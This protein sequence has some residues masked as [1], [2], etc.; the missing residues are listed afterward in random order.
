MIFT[1]QEIC[2]RLHCSKPKAVTLLGK[3]EEQHLIQRTR[4]EKD[5]PYHIVVKA[6]QH[7][8][9]KLDLPSSKNM[10]W[11]SKEILPEQVK[12]FDLN[13]TDNN[14]TDKN[15]TEKI[16]LLEGEIKK[17]I[18]YD[19]LLSA[20]PKDKVDSVVEVMVQTLASSA[21]TISLGGIPVA[22][23]IV[24]EKLRSVTGCKVDYLFD[25]LESYQEP[26]LSYRAFY[27]AR[28]CDPAGVVE[29]YYERR[30]RLDSQSIDYVNFQGEDDA[31]A[32]YSAALLQAFL[33]DAPAWDG[34]S[35]EPYEAAACPN[36]FM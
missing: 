22:A 12:K 9:T 35:Q 17:N 25:N 18:E 24:K 14:K 2:Q 10:T 4:P 27:L 23:E 33:K 1:I 31:P 26:I 11:A 29:E 19:S 21:A 32:E 36:G 20:Y 7:G 16:T 34:F 30:H 13:N 5:G 6:F 3:L 15:K 28:L 8:V